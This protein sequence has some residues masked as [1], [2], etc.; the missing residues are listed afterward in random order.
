MKWLVSKA[1]FKGMPPKSAVSACCWIGLRNPPKPRLRGS[2]P[3]SRPT[4][5]QVTASGIYGAWLALGGMAL[6]ALAL[7]SVRGDWTPGPAPVT[8][9]AVSGALPLDG[10]SRLQPLDDVVL[11]Y[12]GQGEA[13]WDGKV[14]RI[15]WEEGAVTSSVTPKQGIDLSVHTREAVV[16]VVG[17]EFTVTRDVEGSHVSVHHGVVAVDCEAD[18]S[19]TLRAERRTP[20]PRYRRS[21]ALQN[22]PALQ[23]RRRLQ[24]DPDQHRAGH[25]L[26]GIGEPLRGELLA[27]QVQLHLRDGD[28]TAASLVARQYLDEGFTVRA[29]QL[30]AIAQTAP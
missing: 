12:G 2:L 16:S 6:A 8:V 25:P 10:V 20:V 24:T 30:R 21:V 22:R 17:T 19:V 29:P 13:T 3:G 4:V 28:R 9:A 26:L 1:G 5:H 27:R 23:R 14:V 7:L 15:D 11:D 18:G